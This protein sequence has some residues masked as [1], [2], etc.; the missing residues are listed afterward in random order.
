MLS[1]LRRGTVFVFI[2]ILMT[3]CGR[4]SFGGSVGTP[5]M[6]ATATAV[7][8]LVSATATVAPAPTATEVPLPV[9][10]QVRLIQ[11][12]NNSPQPL[13]D[14]L[15]KTAALQQLPIAVD[16]RSPDGS[17]ALASTTSVADRV[18]VWIGTEYDVQQLIKLNV[19][20]E[21]APPITVDHYPLYD[22]AVTHN[23]TY[24][25]MPLAARNYLVS[26]SNSDLLSSIPRSTAELMSINKFITGR[27]HYKMGFSWA[28]GRWFQ[29]VLNQLGASSVLT[30]TGSVLPNEMA[31]TALQSLVD[32]RSLG[33]RDATT[34]V[35][36]TAD[37]VHWRVPFTIDGD[38]AIRRYERNPD[39]LAVN[40]APAPIYSPTGQSLLP[41]VDV[42]YAIIPKLIPAARQAQVIQFIQ[43]LQ[44]LPAQTELVRSMRW[45]PLNRAVAASGALPDDALFAVLAPQIDTLQPQFYDD[46]TI[47]RW[48][49]Y[50]SVLPLVLL[51]DIS[52]QNGVDAINNGLRKCL[53]VP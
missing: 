22:R 12:D 14:V 40:F 49:A 18:D 23:A 8:T 30:D 15:T 42:V 46:I 52:L 32:L 37:F 19:V 3:G 10:I 25:V 2:C 45:V 47:C 51:H 48:D 28:D 29:M 1:E 6:P 21:T 38:A 16:A 26:I 53:I 39:Q 36:S 44:A 31:E 50:E 27:V 13:I 7:A 4:P 43:A 41:P 17:Y 24:M 5:T 11:S 35:E 9:A 34:Y 33:P 20:A